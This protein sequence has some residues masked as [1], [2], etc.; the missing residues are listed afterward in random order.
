L[1]WWA[2]SQIVIKHLAVS[3]IA[4]SRIS[5]KKA[6]NYIAQGKLSIDAVDDK[7]EFTSQYAVALVIENE[8]TYVS[9]KLLEAIQAGCIPV[10]VGPE[11][12][13]EWLPRDLYVRANP[14]VMSIRKALEQ[15]IAMNLAAAQ[16]LQKQWLS[17]TAAQLWS[18]ESVRKQTHELLRKKL[19]ATH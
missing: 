15:A 13:E 1:N 6:F 4:G 16:H 12:S 7:F 10:Y 19:D 14:D 17:S 18:R 3:I 9:E 5:G 8:S 2:K 11:I